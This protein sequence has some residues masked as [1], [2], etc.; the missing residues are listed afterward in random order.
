MWLDMPIPSAVLAAGLCSVSGML[1]DVD[2]DS[3]V[4]L[5]ES[6]CF[7]SAVVPMLLLE[8]LRRSNMPHETVVLVG[9]GIYLFIRFVVA[10]LIKRFTVHRGMFHSLPAAAIVGEM[11][12]LMTMGQDERVRWFKAIAVTAGYLCHLVL[13]EIWSFEIKRG[14]IR[15]K[16]SFGTALKF[17]GESWPAAVP[18]YALLAVLTYAVSQD[19]ETQR[20]LNSGAT[21]VAKPPVQTSTGSG[22]AGQSPLDRATQKLGGLLSR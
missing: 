1:P 15:T 7:A 10:T 2:S 16:A 21:Q 12:Y 9:A 6:I 3:G 14:L 4:P 22:P 13:D 17:I 20:M 18:T 19:P 5:R 11:V 8:Q